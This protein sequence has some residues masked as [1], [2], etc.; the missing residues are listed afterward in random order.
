MPQSYSLR[1]NNATTSVSSLSNSIKSQNPTSPARDDEFGDF[2]ARSSSAI[3]QRATRSSLS[4]LNLL[5][6]NEEDA[7]ARS[8]SMPL[9]GTIQSR[10]TLPSS[11]RPLI[12]NK[13]RQSGPA[14]LRRGG[15]GNRV[16]VTTTK[17]TAL[18]AQPRLK[19]HKGLKASPD[20]G[21]R[22]SLGGVAQP[23]E[24]KNI[25]IMCRSH[26]SFYPSSPTFK[27]QLIFFC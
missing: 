8:V 15:P 10:A 7:F 9:R 3:S 23:D 20:S 25:H 24:N 12:A 13:P 19:T 17:A 5:S 21:A 26:A 14:V 4:S 18:R 11:I 16:V 2:R 27:H 6:S 1:I 22:N